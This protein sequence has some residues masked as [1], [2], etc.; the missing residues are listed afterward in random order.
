MTRNVHAD[1]C[2]FMILC[3][4]ILLRIRNNIFDKVMR[5]IKTRLLYNHFFPEKHAFIM[6]KKHKIH[7]CVSTATMATRTLH[8]ITSYLHCISYCFMRYSYVSLFLRQKWFQLRL[9]ENN[10]LITSFVSLHL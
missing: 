3:R 9:Y 1:L 7:H 4:R 6:S 2:T 5:K 8:N 10:N